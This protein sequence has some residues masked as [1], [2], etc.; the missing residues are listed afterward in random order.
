MKL[1]MHDVRSCILKPAMTDRPEG[2][3]ALPP[4]GAL[5]AFEAAARLESFTRAAEELC[6]T[7]TAISH[8]VRLLEQTLATALFVRL[9]RRIELTETGK[10]WASAVG[11][12]FGRLYA[13]NRALRKAPAYARPTLSVT[14]LPSFAS[15]WL[16]PRLGR[17]LEEQ[18]HVDLRISPSAELVDLQQSEFDVG[19]RYGAG[20]YPS[21]KVE[22][23]C[24]DAWV[25]VC[26][27]ALKR[28]AQLKTPRDLARFTLLRDDERHAWR[29]W[30]AARGVKSVDPEHGP[31]L[32][33]SSMVVEAA[34]Q[35]QGVALVRLSLAADD[36]A[37]GR[38]IMPFPRVEKT[39]TGRSYYLVTTRVSAPRPELSAFCTWLRREIGSLRALGL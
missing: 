24:D 22:K 31:L 34:V 37:A 11:D 4:L 30:L 12:A 19:I 36:L 10:A 5:R 17:F 6:V 1:T 27:P 7:Q 23:L 20:K 9:P 2:P 3:L 18:P 25:V 28:R 8:Q 13:A 15:R 29:T 26:A 14:A 32:T 39:P 21:L 35:A 33:D 38:L 16:V